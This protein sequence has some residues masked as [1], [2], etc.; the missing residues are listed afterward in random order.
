MGILSWLTGHSENRN[1]SRQPDVQVQN[2]FEIP[3]VSVWLA[4]GSIL[5]VVER[6]DA[7]L[8]IPNSKVTLRNRERASLITVT[9][10]QV[11]H[12][13]VWIGPSWHENFCYHVIADAS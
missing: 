1:Q 7:Q 9:D 4:D 11:V 5:T 3:V 12:E 8:V 10:N 13:S 2:V 6:L